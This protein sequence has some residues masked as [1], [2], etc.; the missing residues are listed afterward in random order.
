M[1]CE[2]LNRDE[3]IKNSLKI[4]WY[5]KEAERA[6]ISFNLAA[7]QAAVEEMK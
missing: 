4:W 2:Q 3:E 5:T 7:A 1:G 6:Y